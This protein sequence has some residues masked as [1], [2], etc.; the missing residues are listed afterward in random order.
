M[1]KIFCTHVAI[2]ISL[3]G[4]GAGSEPSKSV[5]LRSEATANAPRAAEL[6]DR[7]AVQRAGAA[8]PHPADADDSPAHAGFNTEAY[9]HVFD[10]AFLPSP[11]TR[12]RHFR[13]TSIRRHIRTFAGF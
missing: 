5:S 9:E 8:A 13:S 3:C 1:R 2:G 4:C 11:A 12:S 6:V 7:P 10:N